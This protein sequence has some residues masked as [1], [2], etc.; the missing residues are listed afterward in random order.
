[1]SLKNKK[2]DVSA[3]RGEWSEFYAF[4][5]LLAEGK[6]YAANKDLTKNENLFYLILKIIRGELEDWEYVRTDVIKI[7]K[8]GGEII[9][10]ISINKLEDFANQLYEGINS[11]LKGKGAFELDFA[12]TIFKDLKTNSL[13]DERKKTAD[14][15]IIIH[16][17]VT[18]HEPLLGFSIKSNVI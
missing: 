1:M 5:K 7:Q 2:E 18:Q 9:S 11:G 13:S 12:K 10:E 6:I 17:P 8:I 14:I 16:D 4:V 15:R 3:N